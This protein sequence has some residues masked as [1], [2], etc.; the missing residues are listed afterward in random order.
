MEYIT[1]ATLGNATIFG[2]LNTRRGYFGGCSDGS[3]G[4]FAGGQSPFVNTIEYITIATPSN[5]IDF[6]DLTQ[7]RSYL[8]GCSDGSRG[9][10]S[11]GF[12]FSTPPATTDV[13]TID[14]ITI[15]TTGNATDFGD[16]TEARDTFG[17]TSGD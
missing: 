2:D 11:G 5:S 7:A 9:I 12:T 16:L 4:I 1:I 14:Y 3:R 17:A 15:A 6:G 13:N 8:V 10:M